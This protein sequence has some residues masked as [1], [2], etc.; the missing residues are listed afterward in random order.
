MDL[1]DRLRTRLDRAAGGWAGSPLRLAAVLCPLVRHEGD[2]HVVFTV[3]P[4]EL[5]QHGGQIA[6]PGGMRDG[7]E[8]PVATALRE[9]GEELGVPEAA[10]DVLGSLPPRESSTGILVHCLVGR[11]APVPLVPDP[12]EVARVLRVP[13]AVLLDDARWS[14]R[15]PPPGAAGRQGRT[16]PHLE[17]GDD[18]LWG[19]TARFLRDLA[20]RLRG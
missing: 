20:A 16:S 12:V 19:L 17:Y 3:R 1:D 10:V 18:L 15:P 6:F 8:T 14:E 7:D 2:D 5:R 4:A 13:L 9:C 11:L